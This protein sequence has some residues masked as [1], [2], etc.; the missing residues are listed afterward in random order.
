MLYGWVDLYRLD[1]RELRPGFP[2]FA[3]RLFFFF[4]CIC[5]GFSSK[6]FEYW[7]L[8]IDT[9]NPNGGNTTAP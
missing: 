8:H 7:Q 5:S 6:P 2:F 3:R 1:R 9:H 4:A